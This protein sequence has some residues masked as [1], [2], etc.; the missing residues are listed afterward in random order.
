MV[1][2][3][4]KIKILRI[5]IFRTAF[6]Q[7]WHHIPVQT[8]PNQTNQCGILQSVQHHVR[9]YQKKFEL[10]RSNGSWDTGS[11]K[12]KIW[13]TK[14]L[15]FFEKWPQGP[16]KRVKNQKKGIFGHLGPKW[17]TKKIFVNFR[18]GVSKSMLLLT[19]R[20]QIQRT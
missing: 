20:R 14:N 2:L 5:G 10:S 18:V 4:K 6:F 8:K 1:S 12:F 11:R 7:N 17:L 13:K 16:P 9:A 15:G 3:A 19:E